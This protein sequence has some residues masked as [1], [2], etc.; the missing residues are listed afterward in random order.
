MV[1]A[2]LPSGEVLF[3]VLEALSQV[4]VQTLSPICD[5]LGYARGAQGIARVRKRRLAGGR[6]I[7]MESPP[8]VLTVACSTTGD[9]IPKRGSGPRVVSTMVP[10]GVVIFLVAVGPDNRLGL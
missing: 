2:L 8:G 6:L 3:I 7:V 9:C 4:E 5:L 10:S 1:V